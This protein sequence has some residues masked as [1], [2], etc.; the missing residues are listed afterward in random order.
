MDV[1]RSSAL[2]ANLQQ[3]RRDVS[4]RAEQRVLLE[5][6]AER[7]GVNQ[8]IHN[9]LA[10]LNHPIAN[11][12]ILVRDL[13][14][15]VLG[16]LHYYLSHPRGAEAIAVLLQIPLDLLSAGLAP[17]LERELLRTLFEFMSSLLEPPQAEQFQSQ[18]GET[19]KLL[20]LHLP[21]SPALW[22]QGSTLLHRHCA[23]FTAFPQLSETYKALFRRALAA[24]Y[25]HWLDQFDLAVW[26]AENRQFFSPEADLDGALAPLH[27]RRLRALLGQA[28]ATATATELLALPHYGTLADEAMQAV[29]AVS[30]PVDRAQFLLFFLDSQLFASH[31]HHLLAR[32]RHCLRTVGVSDPALVA[33]FVR[34]FFSLLETHHFERK[35]IALDTVFSLG[36][37]LHRRGELGLLTAF[38]EHLVRLPFEPPNV[39]GV[40]DQWEMIV[41][42]NHLPNVR[43]FLRLI[44]E[45]PS[46]YRRLLSALIVLLSLDGLFVADTDLFQKDV[47]QLLN[48]DVGPVYNKVKQLARMFPVYFTEI[49]AEGELRDASTEIDQIHER[50]DP[51]IHFLRKQVH[52]ESNSTQV[53]FTRSIIGFWTS[54]DKSSLERWLPPEICAAVQTE[55]PYF[56][57]VHRIFAALSRARPFPDWLSSDYETL[58]RQVDAQKHASVEERKRATLLLKL[59]KLLEEKYF[60]GAQGVVE[61]VRRS[62]LVDAAL[63]N[64]LDQN[65]E[66][67]QPL[68][69]LPLVL[70]ILE[71]LKEI[72]LDPEISQGDERIYRKRHVAAGIPSMYGLYRERKFEALGL[73]FRLETLARRLYAELIASTN[74]RYVTKKTLLRAQDI[75]ALFVRVL[76]LDGMDSTSLENNRQVLAMGLQA[77]DFSV[78]Q[79]VNV[80]QFIAADVQALTDRYVLNVHASTAETIL[81]QRA[82]VDRRAPDASETAYSVSERLLRELITSCFGLQELDDFV[83]KILMALTSMRQEL[84]DRV[85]Q[86]LM[87]YDPYRL[88]SPI[89]GTAQP[90]DNP[91][92]LGSKGYFLKQLGAYGLP[93]PE[94]FILTTELFRCQMALSFGPMQDDTQSRIREHLARL[95]S[96]TNRRFGDPANPLLLSAR[97]GAVMSMPGMM[98]TLLNVGLNDEIAEALGAREGYAWATWDCYRRLIQSWA[99]SHGVDRDVF[100]DAMNDFKRRYGV[101]KKMDFSPVQA[102][103]IAFHYKS[104]MMDHD[105]SFVEEPFEQLI[106]AIQMVLGSWFSDRAANYREQLGIAEQWGTA[107]IVQCMVLGNLNRRSGSGVAMTRNPLRADSEIELYGD[108]SFCSQGEDVVSG[109]VN[110]LP[111]SEAQRQM[112]A[113][114]DSDPTLEQGFPA[115]HGQLK[116]IA[117]FLIEEQGYSHQEIE[118]TFESEDPANLYILQTRSMVYSEQE[119]ARVFVPS[120]ELKD[121]LL[122]RGIGA[123]GGA[124]SGQVAFTDAEIRQLRERDPS[125]TIILIRPDTVPEDFRLIAQ[126]NGLLT[127]RGG[128]TSHAA[129][130]AHRLG[131]TCVVNCRALHVYQESQQAELNGHVI[132]YG[133]WISIDGRQGTIYRGHFPAKNEYIVY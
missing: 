8:R 5:V 22:A 94:G 21:D 10:E 63:V 40:S 45:H 103:E 14:T 51:L 68:K 80:F 97:S 61:Q 72:I 15:I 50:R 87:S 81:A 90:Y 35:N 124:L 27:P 105:V 20:T 32:L 48:A 129:V 96:S 101:E 67:G 6:T 3:T 11:K 107:A 100:D 130:A 89:R 42:P 79:L 78:E 114:D 28:E 91:L 7:F 77:Q 95:E 43:L 118:F 25:E 125:C 33:G 1:F 39:Q 47:S 71:A 121:A 29:E 23:T 88:I 55:G 62:G 99:M 93:V 9:F 31:E 111:I 75:L 46:R 131:K 73:T 112:G 70:D 38:I 116:R 102:R 52:V 13:R 44:E 119:V 34:R 117:Q 85:L 106:R 86:L 18:V 127:A 113:T 56:D 69:T 66:T 49:G 54:G 74:L 12:E 36:Q 84:D 19:L 53:A 24:T 2:R 98:S 109:L 132:R 123:G 26:Y 57:E 128:G 30:E 83:G 41:N 59:Y 133:D 126:A 58:A 108:Y 104:I 76:R 16:D 120:E 110:P 92:H 17:E 4:I 60:F 122:G 37:E 115:I 82:G 65:L 64:R